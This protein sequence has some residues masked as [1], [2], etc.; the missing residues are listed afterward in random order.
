MTGTKVVGLI[1]LGNVGRPIGERLLEA[2]F[3][4]RVF[5]LN[6]T[7]MDRL[8]KLGAAPALSA[9]DAVSEI[10][11]TVLPSSVEVEMAVLGADGILLGMKKGYILVDLSGTDPDCARNIERR[12]EEKE[13]HFIGGTIHASGAPAVIIPKGLLAIAV[14]GNSDAIEACQDVLT[15]IARKVIC[16]PDVATPKALKLA[17]RM[18]GVVNHII[19]AEVFAWLLAQGIDPRL[20]YKLLRE[21]GSQAVAST[22]KSFLGRHNSYGG[23][24]RLSQKDLREA[25]KVAA[26]LDLPLP[27]TALAE[28]MMQL[29]RAKGLEGVNSPGA[30]GKL[31]EDLTGKLMEQAVLPAEERTFNEPQGERIVKLVV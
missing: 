9:E 22:V 15:A 2:G 11:L 28:Q 21:T 6:P 29:A 17:A 10:T 1:G 4:L 18:M 25:L 30:I 24:L 8:V 31:Y 5:D 3:S 13:A 16:L 19:S 26:A 27:F 14:G 20:F 12:I 7:A 23:M